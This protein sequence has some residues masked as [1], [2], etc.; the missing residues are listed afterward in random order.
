MRVFIKF[1]FSGN[2]FKALVFL[3][4]FGAIDWTLPRG[5]SVADVVS[6]NLLK[7]SLTNDQHVAASLLIVEGYK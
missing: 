1:I 2:F 5:S 7:Q 4:C 3:I 6:T